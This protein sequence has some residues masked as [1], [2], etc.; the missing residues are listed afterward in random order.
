M[1]PDILVTIA[2]PD[3]YFPRGAMCTQA[4]TSNIKL[5]IL[6]LRLI[7]AVSEVQ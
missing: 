1:A 6:P 7:N 3:I 2:S 4:H 5:K